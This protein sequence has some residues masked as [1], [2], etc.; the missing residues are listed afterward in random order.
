MSG[1]HSFPDSARSFLFILSIIYDLRL[2]TSV[3]DVLARI[4][5][6]YVRFYSPD[7]RLSS[8]PQSYFL[9]RAQRR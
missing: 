8:L 3:S 7:F 5:I 1:N 2:I 9:S 6:I 4:T